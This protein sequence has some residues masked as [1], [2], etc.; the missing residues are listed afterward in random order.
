VVAA[1]LCGLEDG[2]A[3]QSNEWL[4]RYPD[5]AP[6]LEAF[7]H[8]RERFAR[9]AGP[10]RAALGT[11]PPAG[12]TV[13]Y[14]G[15][16]ELL[17]EIAR[18]GMGLVYKA[19]QLSLNRVVALKMILTGSLATPADLTRFRAEAE[20]A[21]NLDHPN[22]VPI[23]E[24]GEH[25]GRPY[26]SMKLV[27]GGTLKMDGGQWTAAG[28][29]KAAR[30]LAKVARAVHH[31]HQHGIL[32]RDLKP[33]NVLVDAQGEPHVTDFG[34]AKRVRAESGAAELTQS[35][36]IVGTPS[37]MAPEQAAGKKGLSTAADVYSLGA[38]LYEGLTGRPPFRA[39][40]VLDTLRQVLDEEPPRPRSVN[41][42]VDRD[43]ET[44]AVKCL[45][46][47]PVRRYGSAA[48]LADDLERWLAGEPIQARPSS[49]WERAAKWARRRPALAALAAVS[50]LAF[51][52][53]LILGLVYEARLTTA[54]SGIDEQKQAATTARL[55]A[56]REHEAA[57]VAAREAGDK[58]REAKQANDDAQSLLRE[59]KGLRCTAASGAV[60]PTNPGLALLLGIEGAERAPGFLANNALLAA[61]NA[62]H[63]ERTLSGHDWDTESAEFSPDGRH[64][65][66]LD[67][68][69]TLRLWEVATG[70]VLSV[71]GLGG[72]GIRTQAHFSPDGRYVVTTYD[73][74]AVCRYPDDVER[75]YTDRVARV[76]DA[77]RGKLHIVLRGHKSRVTTAEFSPDGKHIV[78]ASYDGTARIW[79]V[80]TG[81]ELRT[82][83]EHSSALLCASF[84]PDG[85][86]VLTVFQNRKYRRA[87]DEKLTTH[88]DAPIDPPEILPMPG[89]SS[90]N[91]SGSAGPANDPVLA[92]LW[93][94]ESGKEIGVP[95]ERE[96]GHWGT[97][98]E[99]S[100]NLGM[101]SPD[102]SNILIVTREPVP[103][104]AGRI[105]FDVVAVARV[106][107]PAT[108]KLAARI[109]DATP[110]IVAAA[111]SKDGKK[112]LT[113]SVG[114]VRLWD[115]AT[116]KESVTLKGHKRAITSAQL[117]A[118]GRLIVT[119]SADRTARVWDAGTG[120]E[121][122]VLRG[123][124]EA[125]N[126][127]A[128]DRD[129]R[130]VVTASRDRTAR[131]WLVASTSE[132]ALIL[133]GHA[134]NVSSIS[135]RADGRRVVT[136][137]ADRTARIWDVDSGNGLQL[138]KGQE[139][140]SR[141]PFVETLGEVQTAVFSPDGKRVLTNSRD[142]IS[143]IKLADG[144]EEVL[145]YTPAR[146]WDAETGRETL[147]FPG[148][149]AQLQLVDF[150]RDGRFVLTAENG[151]ETRS[152]LH[153]GPRATHSSGGNALKETAVCIWDAAGG[154]LLQTLKGHRGGILSAAFSPDG[155]RVLTSSDAD[156]Q[157]AVVRIWETASGK[158][159]F[160]LKGGR[161]GLFSPDGRRVLTLSYSNELRLWDA[162]T[163]KAIT[164]LEKTRRTG[165]GVPF[166]RRFAD[167]AFSPDGSRVVVIVSGQVSLD[168]QQLGVWDTAT[169][170]QMLLWQAHTRP[171][172]AVG[173]SHNGR[174]LLTASDD[175]TARIWDAAT[176]KE[177]YTLTGHEGGVLDAAFSP[178]DTRVATASTDGTSRLW[179]TDLLRIARA[180]KP[181]EL[182]AEERNRFDVP[183]TK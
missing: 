162:A 34:L 81:K 158:E 59:A 169:G 9:W 131:I 72:Y 109:Q 60:L 178:D 29:H 142:Q 125:V 155:T 47:D 31:A 14:F 70:K 104:P 117:S 33:A 3:P 37:Y 49:T 150:S 100:A 149:A 141:Y 103:G 45:E 73:G 85:K 26:F 15:D 46:K 180:R 52:A 129:A 65:L 55:Q 112:L 4:A 1:Y 164:W 75:A 171:I 56:G 172:N 167:A 106:F 20:A 84:S 69:G 43:L 25:D 51:A 176:G 174:W 8:N 179:M 17:E 32:H 177:L 13:G 183:S 148:S 38:M 107:D 163:G 82:L 10:V 121:V 102:G 40:S 5:L 42:R 24:V 130:R 54:M 11:A 175:E 91:A 160:A 6:Q 96:K 18:G 145:P 157:N 2:T 39:D 76:W 30:L 119:S 74:H 99:G 62:N 115:V 77:A 165:Y 147:S 44:I 90:N 123:H 101:F 98:S 124:D 161:F 151:R 118:D 66:T 134:G 146:L 114:S 94:A 127:A 58:R 48:F 122:A 173:F 152:V 132:H 113:A 88:P 78:T 182:T 111:F 87:A 16:Y 137:S 138:L 68:A 166:G 126:T 86:R 7:L 93:D 110:P 27:D 61:L 153:I 89:N 135:F 144:K 64:V 35:G 108:G 28:E 105:P 92:R 181:R 12:T 71:P 156:L 133:K 63:E 170:K 57:L 120:E 21:G 139:N 41:S 168:R 95:L 50:V 136:A 159:L 97:V 83:T 22:I 79:D 128:F 143:R 154:K 53:L 140:T 116:Q 36:S 80:A 19:R 23:Y 67:H